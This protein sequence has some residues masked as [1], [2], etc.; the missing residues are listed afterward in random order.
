MV[1]EFRRIPAS[2][3][4]VCPLMPGTPVPSVTMRAIDG[5]EVDSGTAVGEKPSVLVFYRG[6]W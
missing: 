2:P 4:D 6:G 3:K 5:S 1:Q